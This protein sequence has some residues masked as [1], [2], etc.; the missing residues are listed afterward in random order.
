MSPDPKKRDASASPANDN[1]HELT[2]AE[3]KADLEKAGIG[4]LVKQL[5]TDYPKLS[6]AMAIEH[7]HG[8]LPFVRALKKLVANCETPG[9]LAP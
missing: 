2:H 8:F 5:M 7:L 3:M 6:E 1:A 4:H 9:R